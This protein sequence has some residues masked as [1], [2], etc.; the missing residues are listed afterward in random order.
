MALP[1][2]GQE[3]PA[4]P[5]GVVGIPA[6]FASPAAD[7]WALPGIS[8]ASPTGWAYP[9]ATAG[10]T[11]NLPSPESAGEP[12]LQRFERGDLVAVIG[13]EYVLAGDLLPF[14]DQQLHEIAQKV[15]EDQV[16]MYRER[17]TR[18]SLA[19]VVQSKLLAQFFID[20]QVAGKPL[21][22]R[23][24][25]RKQ[26]SKRVAEAFYTEVV[27]GLM[28]KQKVDTPLELDRALRAEGTS[29]NAQFM[30]F[31][32]TVFA[33]E[34][35]K[36]HVPKKFDIDLIS[37]R[38]YYEA[39]LSDFQRPA[40]A[41]FREL[42]AMYA[43][44]SSREEARLLI[45]QMGAEVLGGAAFEAVS[46]KYSQGVRAAEGGLYD[47]TTQGSL[48]SAKVDEA[49]FAIPLRRL[50]WIIEDDEGFKIIEVMER[51]L[52]RV[53]PFEEAQ[54]E[55]RKALS[56]Q[57]EANARE[58]LMERLRQNSA[59]WSRWPEDI[60]G[61]KPLSELSPSFASTASDGSGE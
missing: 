4:N 47:W 57:R 60:P 49:V 2:S 22:E 17:L 44:H 19:Q 58:K 3:F 1:L 16:E 21:N 31:K 59:I 12:T 37:L 6:A 55:I 24:D 54:L 23:D 8:A 11:L 28:K 36:Q 34:A 5:S 9:A 27:P 20:D 41:R 48:R 26:M 61:A 14:F 39:H 33:Q 25:A 13:E 32:D 50:S 15:P 30:V 38:D 45:E 51:E 42:V 29:L 53:V 10:E 18:Q 43:R 56:K 7:G 52:A 35:V 46:Q 40:R